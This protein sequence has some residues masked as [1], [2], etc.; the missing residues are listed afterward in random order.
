MLLWTVLMDAARHFND[1]SRTVKLC[2]LLGDHG[3]VIAFIEDDEEEKT[4][5]RTE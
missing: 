2:S 1:A 4:E 5:H 3:E